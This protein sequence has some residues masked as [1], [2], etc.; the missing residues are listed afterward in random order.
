MRFDMKLKNVFS[1]FLLVL[2]SIV[3]ACTAVFAFGAYSADVGM[4]RIRLYVN[5][6]LRGETIL[7]VHPVGEISAFT[8]N[9]PLSLNIELDRLRKDAVEGIITNKIKYE[10]LLE[11]M[12]K[13]VPFVLEKFIIRILLL[14][15]CGG[16]LG[17]LIGR[18]IRFSNM[19]AGAIIGVIFVG[20]MGY[21]TYADFNY[22]EF[23][24]PNYKGLIT[25]A[26]DLVEVVNKS[27]TKGNNLQQYIR[28]MANNISSFYIEMDRYATKDNGVHLRILHIS[29]IHNNPLA[30]DF[31]RMLVKGLSPDIILDTGDIT[32]MGTGLEM[33][34]SE[35]LKGIGKPHYYVSGNHDSPEVLDTLRTSF[36]IRVLDG[37]VVVTRGLR[38]MG[39]GDP[40]SLKPFESEED[41]KEINLLA[42]RIHN[43]ITRMKAPP[44]ILMVHNPDVAE[45]MAGLVPLILCGH[46][47]NI[48][49]REKKGT[50]IIVSGTTGASGLRYIEAKKKP[51]YSAAII[52]AHRLNKRYI[53]DYVDLIQMNQSTGEFKIQRR[54]FQEASQEAQSK[55][56]P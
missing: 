21:L 10:A 31:V 35:T 13:Q 56:A 32:D 16:L 20:A 30:G 18:R 44:D 36:R 42:E 2:I 5:P 51:D 37:E 24:Q 45:L 55:I 40:K 54:F 27:I 43:R 47:H 22:R 9:T 6:A 23:K 52:T 29:D 48:S 8:H 26:P 38:I 33:H 46:N 14:A 41:P 28:D 15:G 39:Y 19:A 4:V 53:F 7:V 25:Y 3:A 11:K 50:I 12:E 49:V 17:A 34:L 1:W